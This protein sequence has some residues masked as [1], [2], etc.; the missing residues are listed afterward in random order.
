MFVP[1][2]S[3]GH[4][5]KEFR[6]IEDVWPSYQSGRLTKRVV[7]TKKAYEIDIVTPIWN[8]GTWIL[9][10]NDFY[11]LQRNT[12]GLTFCLVCYQLH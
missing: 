4:F 5:S 2:P 11:K 1:H 10:W 8:M 7:Y 9:N 12:E 3:L 6:D